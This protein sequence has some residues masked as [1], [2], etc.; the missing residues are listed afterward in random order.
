MPC[1]PT[2][3]CS[4]VLIQEE[5]IEDTEKPM[6]VPG[7]YTTVMLYGES[8]PITFPSQNQHEPSYNPDKAYY[9]GHSGL[10][11]IYLC[12]KNHLRPHEVVCVILGY[13]DFETIQRN[14]FKVSHF[15]TI[16]TPDLRPMHMSG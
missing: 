8:R 6:L 12:S 10:I 1:S 11:I 15:S 7:M 5:E 16:L 13:L 2:T 14:D 4:F 3:P 9:Y